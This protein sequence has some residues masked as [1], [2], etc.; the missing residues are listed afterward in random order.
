MA[1]PKDSKEEWSVT[2]HTL[3][4]G[5]QTIPYKASAG[6]TLLKDNAGEPTGLLYSVAYTRSDVRDPSTRPISFL[7]NG[8]PGL[9]DDVAAHGRVR[10]EARVDA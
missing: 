4:V 10:P 9:R 2:D 7:Y 8:G 1:Q 6:T 5:A 3:K